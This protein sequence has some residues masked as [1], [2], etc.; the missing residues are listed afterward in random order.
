M[1]FKISPD[2]ISSFFIDC[3]DTLWYFYHFKISMRDFQV[4]CDIVLVRK[5]SKLHVSGSQG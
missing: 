3:T 4:L 5:Q 2:S 1:L